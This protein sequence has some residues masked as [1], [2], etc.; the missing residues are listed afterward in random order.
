MSERDTDN[1]L[2]D[3]LKHMTNDHDRYFDRETAQYLISRLSVE[4]LLKPERVSNL[5]NFVVSSGFFGHILTKKSYYIDEEDYSS[6][7]EWRELLIQKDPKL[8]EY[9][10]M[11]FIPAG[12]RD[13]TPKYK[14]HVEI[15]GNF[16]DFYVIRH[17]DDWTKINHMEIYGHK[18]SDINPVIFTLESLCDEQDSNYYP[19]RDKKTVHISNMIIDYIAQGKEEVIKNHW[20]D[21]KSFT[22]KLFSSK[23]LKSVMKDVEP[24]TLEKLFTEESLGTIIRKVNYHDH[25]KSNPALLG[26]LLALAPAEKWMDGWRKLHKS[27]S[28]NIVELFNNKFYAAYGINI[29]NNQKPGTKKDKTSI[30]GS[31]AANEAL[32]DEMEFFLPAISNMKVEKQQLCQ[33]FYGLMRSKDAELMSLY[34]DY[35]DIPTVSATDTDELVKTHT[36]VME[37]FNKEDFISY[38]IKNNETGEVENKQANSWREVYADIKAHKLDSILERKEEV[39]IK[40]KLKI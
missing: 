40:R 16:S 2:L 15:K 31:M 17:F 28:I 18:L 38:N 19:D 11:I 24:E 35:F 9:P 23:R 26:N 7:N 36:K 32:M 21:E 37:R 33:F 12:T 34:L 10:E 27:K 8:G 6:I 22:N 25:I 5:K 20:H 13:Q 14:D 3:L 29:Y 30:G 39:P 1:K 4:S